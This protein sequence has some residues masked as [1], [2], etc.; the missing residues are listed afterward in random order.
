MRDFERRQY[1]LESNPWWRAGGGW[2]QRDPDLREAR[3]NEL[4]AYDPRPLEDLAPESLYLLMGPRRAGKSV[5]VKRAIAQLLV[6]GVD[7][8]RIAFCACEGLSK[9]DLRRVVK[10]ATD[11]TP[12]VADEERY[13]LFD[14]ITYV[15]DWDEALKQL[16]DQT[17]LRSG[18]V[19]ATGSSGAR[20]REARG[21]LGG[22]EGPGGGVRLLLPMGFRDFLREAYPDLAAS[23]P[24]SV[25]DPRDL[26]SAAGKRYLEPL[27]VHVDECALAWERYLTIGGFPRAV[28]DA[29]HAVDVQRGTF[30]GLWNIIVG[31]VLRVG[32]MSD[33]DVDS[34]MRCLVE[35]L[36]SPLSVAKVA[37]TLGIGSRNTVA[38]RIDRLCASFY[39]WRAPITHDG[40]N[41]V[42]GG[43]D[44]LYFTDPLAARLVSLRD[45]AA[46][47][48]DLTVLSE[49]QIGVGLLRAVARD[50]LDPVLDE[51]ALLVRRHPDSGSEIDFVGTHVGTPIESKYVSQKWKPERRGLEEHYRR[52]IVATR[53]ILDLSDSVWAVPAALLVWTIDG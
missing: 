38:D 1:L 35:R 43:L 4:S 6:R 3:L 21:E 33:R 27:A 18:C 37:R 28:A 52:G 16:R 19:M 23:L 31:D 24:A 14:E 34:L 5:A 2:E 47:L 51:T 12:G 26:Q 7:P 17:A 36:G 32:A 40:E 9:Q 25:V 41:R 15:R 44:K 20:L 29:L 8:R 49:Q 10:L 46:P 45:G 53:D 42:V 30:N 48:P 39:S 13:W 22:R 11:L 50:T